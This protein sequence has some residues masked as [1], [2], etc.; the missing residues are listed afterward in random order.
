MKIIYSQWRLSVSLNMVLFIVV[1]SIST[2]GKFARGQS[3]IHPG[4][5]HTQ[6]D[7]NRMREKVNAGEQPW[8][9]SYD[10]L[11]AS[12][13]AQ[14]GWNPRATATVIRGG[15]GDNVALLYNDVAAA[16]QHALLW[17]ITANA[18]H[19][20]KARDILNAWSATHTTLS[21]NADRYLASGLF[22]YQFANAAEMM[23]GYPGF[24]VARFQNYLLNVYYYP[25]IERFLWSN[26]Y[27]DDHNDA[28]ITNYW[29]NWDLCNMAAALA[30]GVFCDNRAIF[31]RAIEYFK[32]G[33]GNGSVKHAVPFIHSSTLAQWQESGRDQGHSLLG[34]GLMASFCEIA[35]SQ[36]EN[37]YGYDNGRFR[38]GAE[39]VASYNLG[40]TVPFT[41]YAWGS[42][43]NCAYNQHTVISS[44][45]RGEWRPIWEMIYNHY[46]KRVGQAGLIPNIAAYAANMR[47]EGGPGGHATTFD[48]PGFGSLTFFLVDPS[49]PGG[50]TICS[51]EGQTC[52][53]SG[54]VNIAYG[55]NG[56]FSYKYDVSGGSI[57]CNNATFGDP[58]RG[59]VKACYV[60]QVSAVAENYY[61]NIS[62]R[63]SG[64]SIDVQNFSVS[65]GGNIIQWSYNGTNNQQWK[66]QNAG[67]GYYYV[68]SRQSGKCLRVV[69]GDIQQYTCTTG[70]WSEQFDIITQ[71]SYYQ[72]RNRETGNCL[73]VANSSTTNGADIVEAACNNSLLSQLFSFSSVGNA[74]ARSAESILVSPS[75]S[76]IKEVDFSIYPNPVTSVLSLNLPEEFANGEAH[77]VDLTGK[78]I[79][80]AAP[81]QKN[82]SLD[83]SSLK[84]GTYLFVI[85]NNAR[86]RTIK[87]LKVDA[88]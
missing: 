49:S 38:K 83:V 9:G 57:G 62:N 80:R 18:A 23:R 76:D 51:N 25:L 45:G 87:F 42:G 68:V 81:T 27:G 34:V 26:Q 12:A 56:Q 86:S 2:F 71:G 32:T 19:G 35:W 74:S 31:N 69:S 78:E 60:Q 44:A 55:A 7:F 21:G 88:R 72:V 11:V 6:A 58:I 63:N 43:Q 46:A 82:Q 73:Q 15:T 40:N 85:K 48:Q 54:M 47:P 65:D 36:G 30:I 70:W 64:K 59:V 1:L 61:Y 37:M 8:K 79:L 22:G 13:Q 14:L 5:L 66:L 10:K 52:T 84:P 33:A 77:I 16:Y 3:F 50:Y 4:V 75:S 67:D 28:C 17:K 53:F 20:D 41:T 29:A 39:Y 24:D